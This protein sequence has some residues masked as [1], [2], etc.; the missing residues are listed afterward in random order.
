MVKTNFTNAR[1]LADCNIAFKE[2]QAS[3]RMAI[4]KLYYLLKSI[5]PNKMRLKHSVIY[6]KDIETERELWTVKFETGYLEITVYSE[7]DNKEI[8]SYFQE[9]VEDVIDTLSTIIQ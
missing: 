3:N 7:E 5:M 2:Y 8:D 9:T 4:S 1:Q 6:I